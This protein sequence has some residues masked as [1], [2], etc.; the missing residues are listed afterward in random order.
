MR[1]STATTAAARVAFMIGHPIA[2]AV[3]PERFNA[4]ALAGGHD[5]VMTPLNLSAPSVADFLALLRGAENALGAVVTAPHKHAVLGAMDRLSDDARIVGA[6]N[7]VIR[8]A[9]GALIGD[10]TD[11]AGFVVAMADHGVTPKGARG[12]VFG[13]GGA[14]ASI[15]ARLVAG[16]AHVDLVDTDTAKAR[17]LAD[18]LSPL[19]QGR[20][21][22]VARP[23]T[24]SGYDL[25]VNAS[26]VGLDGVSM[27][28]EL[29]G[30]SPGTLVGD[31]V[32]QPAVTAFLKTAEDRGGVIQ[33]GAE[34][35]GAQLPLV[36]SRFG[37]TA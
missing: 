31:V 18:Q 16:G 6:V 17:D 4:W 22:Q 28:H 27:V 2:H 20:A 10:N 3:M 19:T 24:V 21:Q 8:G 33:T 26:S 30:L 37:L 9:D 15:A 23:S 29:G 1:R 25:V 35:A 14:G 36:L 5:V 13:C 7:V 12:L 32:T 11:G 34:M